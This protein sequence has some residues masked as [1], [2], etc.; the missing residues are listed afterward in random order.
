MAC[1]Q[2]AGDLQDHAPTQDLVGSDVVLARLR[3]GDRTAVFSAG[4]FPPALPFARLVERVG[5]L[6]EHALILSREAELS[7]PQVRALENAVRALPEPIEIDSPDMLESDR[8]TL[9][10][11]PAAAG[12]RL[13]ASYS[14]LPKALFQ[15]V[16]PTPVRQPE[17]VILNRRL[18]EELG[19]DAMALA[20][21]AQAGVFTGNLLPDGAVPIAQAYAGHQFGH[22][23]QLGDG[24]AILL[25][26]Q[27]TPD[28]RRVDV[29]LKGAGRTAFSRGGD[30]RA[31]LGPMLREH[32]VS[33]A[34]HALGVPTT[35]SLAVAATGEPVLREIPL[36]GAVLTRVA[37]SHLRVGTFE[38][39]SAR[40]DL[41]LLRTL[42]DYTLARHFPAA[43]EAENPYLA[44]LEA[45]VERQAALIARW[46]LLGFVHG[47]M[48]TDNMA[49]AG[50]TL[51]Y[52]PC[53][54]LD[55]YD[56]ST[57]FSSIDS[58][59]RYAYGRQPQIAQ[60]NVSR[61]AETLLPLLGE[62]SGATPEAA[63]ERGQA[64]VDVFPARFHRHWLAGMKAKLGLVTEEPGDSELIDHLLRL[65][66]ERRSDFTNTFR[67]L[68]A[69]ELPDQ[70]PAYGDWLAAWTARLGRQ[71]IEK[72]ELLARMCGHNPA[73]I[74]RNHKVEEAL[75]AAWQRQD[76]GP[77]H[78]LLEAL[79]D[80]YDHTLAREAYQEPAPPSA[81]AYR[82]F[83]GT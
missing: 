28:G 70:D 12:W 57:V 45:V 50:E 3:A 81:R 49:V 30:G 66:Q 48:N 46:L 72:P 34:L 17:L 56:P 73:V 23:T 47:V 64:A 68:C 51:D 20:Q 21:P 5:G 27:L 53:A 13:G 62:T 83:C 7:E 37:A 65:M 54:F 42:A 33:E 4:L 1:R 10:T 59:G 19:L 11:P 74:A 24:R 58:G 79:A 2:I 63:L 36:P 55:V 80:P 6:R 41:V 32:I 35:R 22:F 18:A 39:A 69:E 52:G 31:A 44:L 67:A 9:L 14:R 76:L 61:F 75:E 26:E 25:G 71:P 78:R 29:Q 40:R 8:S 77:L 60:W 16:R 43:A 15:T 82:T 38:Y